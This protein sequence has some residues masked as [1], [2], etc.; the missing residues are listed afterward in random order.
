MKNYFLISIMVFPIGIFAQGPN[1]SYNPPPQA[2]Q[3]QTVNY[4]QLTLNNDNIQMQA[5]TG[6]QGWNPPVQVQQQQ[7]SGSIFGENENNSYNDYS[8]V[9][10]KFTTLHV[11]SASHHRKN[12]TVKNR[13]NKFSGR[14]RMKMQKMF[15]HRK[16]IRTTY[17]VCFKW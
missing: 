12:F 11:S 2:A 8:A 5:N 13:V 6:N 1:T 10:E 17:E 15:A 4:N 7:A 14:M 3:M 9:K 16:K